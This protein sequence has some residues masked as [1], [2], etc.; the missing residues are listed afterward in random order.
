MKVSWHFLEYM[1]FGY[2][3]FATVSFHRTAISSTLYYLIS[4]SYS[5]SARKVSMNLMLWALPVESTFSGSIIWMSPSD[6]LIIMNH[7][8]VVTMVTLGQ[9]NLL[10]VQILSYC[11]SPSIFTMS[12]HINKRVWLRTVTSTCRTKKMVAKSKNILWFDAPLPM[13]SLPRSASS[14]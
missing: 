1:D 3:L 5:M 12:A 6:Y 2:I 7:Q 9:E 4:F 10:V 11:Q 8:A 14:L 13:A